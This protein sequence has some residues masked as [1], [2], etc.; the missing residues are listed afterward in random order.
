[1]I[2]LGLPPE[3]IERVKRYY[4]E[5]VRGE[6]AELKSDYWIDHSAHAK[7]VF[8][9]DCV[10]LSGASGFYIPREKARSAKYRLRRWVEGRYKRFV[11]ACDKLLRLSSPYALSSFMTYDMA[12]DYILGRR[13]QVSAD[14]YGENPYLFNTGYLSPVFKTSKELEARWF[15]KGRYLPDGNTFLAAYYHAVFN[16]FVDGPVPRYLEVGAGNGNLASFFRYYNKS[17]IVVIDLPEILLFSSCY[18]KSIFPDATIALPHEIREPIAQE[19][20]DENDFVL[21]VPSQS[22]WLPRKAFDLAVNTA[23]MQ[24]MTYEQIGEYIELIQDVCKKGALWCN[25]NRVE[26]FTSRQGRPICAFEFPYYK[27]NKLLVHQI[28]RFHRLVQP[29]NVVIHIERISS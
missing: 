18:L 10:L 1:M 8:Q 22:Q 4:N 7:I 6:F 26:K 27:G 3:Y 5:L 20:L 12:Y 19:S 17:H 13:P 23:S 11:F 9:E 29:D 14:E 28:D 2:R 24:E 16:H 15:L 25:V 21:L